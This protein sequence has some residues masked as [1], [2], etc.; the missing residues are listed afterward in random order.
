MI[1]TRDN[2]ALASRFG[3]F[4]VSSPPLMQQHHALFRNETLHSGIFN[5]DQQT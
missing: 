3:N 2:F 5:T 4:I 1:T